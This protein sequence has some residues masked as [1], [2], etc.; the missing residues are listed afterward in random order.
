MTTLPPIIYQHIN[1][2]PESP[3][4]HNASVPPS[5][6]RLIMRLLAKPKAE[7]P[8]FADEVLVELERVALDRAGESSQ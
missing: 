3:V 4:E 1:T 5:L 6:E 7:R 2:E 8:G